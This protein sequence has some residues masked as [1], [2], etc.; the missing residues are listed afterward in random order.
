LNGFSGELHMAKLNEQSKTEQTGRRLKSEMRVYCG[1]TR[2]TQLSGFTVDLST[3]GLYLQTDYPF[4]VDENLMLSFKLPAQ[5][6]TVSCNAR[7]AWVNLEEN[8]RKPELPAGAGIQ[9]VDLSL[10]D[11]K[12]IRRFLEHN[13]IEPTW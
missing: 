13:E 10:D 4:A 7:V 12:S 6:K 8:P 11:L 9:F 3:G 2:Q 1:P 5:E